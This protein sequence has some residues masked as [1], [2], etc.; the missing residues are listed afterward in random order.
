[1]KVLFIY[2]NLNAQVGFNYGI[3][4]LSACLKERGHSTALLNINENIGFELDL[5][6]IRK[7]V[8]AFAPDLI[9]FSVVTNQYRFAREIA[10]DI[11]AYCD[12]PVVCGGIH[13]TMDP[14]SVLREDCFD[15]ACIGEGEHAIV[16]LADALRSNPFPEKTTRSS[17]S[18]G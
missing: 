18:R 15:Y 17:I 2:P 16:E 13:P 8:A 7:E 6:R 9:G 4:F 5:A 14:E 10:R 3:A 1:M 12:A 11:K